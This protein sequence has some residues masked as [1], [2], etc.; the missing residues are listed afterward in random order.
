MET[1][2]PT[3]PMRTSS[4]DPPDLRLLLPSR[5]ESVSLV[6]YMLGGLT[7]V[8]GI[9]E[10]LQIDINAAVSE[11]CNNVVIHAYPE[12]EGPLEVYICPES[13][14]LEIVV[15]D[16]GQGIRPQPVVEPA[17][18]GEVKGVGLSLIQALAHRASFG[19]GPGEGTEVRMSFDVKLDLDRLKAEMLEEREGVIPPPGEIV[20]SVV[21]GPL[22]GPVLGRVVSILGARQ[23]FS[24]EQLADAG[25]LTDA[26]AAHAGKFVLGRH[27]H[28]ALDEGEGDVILRVG[29]FGDEGGSRAVASSS[30]AGL[31]PLLEQLSAGTTIEQ[32][33]GGE[34]LVLRLPDGR[35][36]S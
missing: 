30:L 3:L 9:D 29:L 16:R 28:V 20:L 36:S 22:A 8:L 13:S 2:L 26:I 25:L 21:N 32:I 1:Y 34:Y 35:Q 15:R 24:I 4:D 12:G 19:G 11:A 33:D 27:L 31:R 5:P 17:S 18:E 6:R 14:E 23:G 10:D 7:D